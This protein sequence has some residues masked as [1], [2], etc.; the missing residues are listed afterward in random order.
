MGS[1]IWDLRDGISEILLLKVITTACLFLTN[2]EKLI[3]RQ[4][5]KTRYST[6]LLHGQNITKH[7][8]F[9]HFR[10]FPITSYGQRTC[11]S[12]KQFFGQK[13]IFDASQNVF[14]AF[15]SLFIVSCGDYL[16]NCFDYIH[17]F[18]NVQ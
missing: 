6:N 15:P 11:W 2:L 3:E 18:H 10:A 17:Q 1:Q 13:M 14:Y 12:F 16:I 4:N 8:N 5:S 7:T 9:L